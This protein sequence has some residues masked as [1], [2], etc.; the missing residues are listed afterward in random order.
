MLTRDELSGIVEVMVVLSE[1][2]IVE[3][4]QEL[5][6]MRDEK[7]PE[8]DDLRHLVESAL[9]IHW[10]E[11]IPPTALCNALTGSK[12]YIAGPASF[13]TVPPELSEIME[14][15]EF[16]GCRS[17][18]WELVSSN[19][20]SAMSKRIARL[21]AMV[22]EVAGSALVLEKAEAEYGELFNLYYDYNF[23]LPDGLVG[24]GAR[25]EMISS[26]LKELKERKLK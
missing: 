20:I 8:L 23:W 18:D 21:E 6:F 12:F 3:I 26:R 25:L 11:S 19:I 7:N 4:S 1:E 17:F 5:A 13:G 22:E 2:E 9:K 24:I 16:E 10:L 15:I 14:I